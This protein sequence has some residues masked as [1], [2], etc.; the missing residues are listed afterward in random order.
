MLSGNSLS[1]SRAWK[2]SSSKNL[3]EEI[4]IY[5]KEDKNIDLDKI[6]EKEEKYIQNIE[7]ALCTK[8]FTTEQD[9]RGRFTSHSSTNWDWLRKSG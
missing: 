8:A 6:K 4:K 7:K 5:L 1:K 9:G 2:V 3:Y